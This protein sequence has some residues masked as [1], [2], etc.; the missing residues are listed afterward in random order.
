MSDYLLRYHELY[1]DRITKLKDQ[2]KEL[3]QKLNDEEFKRHEVVKLAFRVRQA[4]QEI[5]PQDPDRPEYRLTGELK[6][7]SRYK[8]GLQRYRLF[9]CFSREPKMI[10]YLY[11]NDEKHLRKAGAKTDPYEEF[12]KLVGKGYFSHDPKDQKIRKWVREYA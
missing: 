11:L 3:R 10:L 2:V 1:Y 6:K 4:D 7:Y 5:I 12:R 9:F 8:H